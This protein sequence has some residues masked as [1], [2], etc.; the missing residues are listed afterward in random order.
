MWMEK[1]KS[2]RCQRGRGA[3]NETLLAIEGKEKRENYRG[4]NFVNPITRGGNERYTTKGKPRHLHG[5]SSG[6]K[7]EGIKEG[8]SIISVK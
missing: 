8:G 4:S 3:G 7:G 6:R 1:Q 2:V 5:V